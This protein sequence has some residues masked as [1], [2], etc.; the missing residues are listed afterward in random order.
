MQLAELERPKTIL[1]ALLHGL[2]HPRQRKDEIA[3][4]NPPDTIDRMQGATE[5]EMAVWQIESGFN[6]LQ[7]IRLALQ[8]IDEGTYGTCVACDNAIGQKRLNAIPWAS[9]CVKCQDNA[10][11]QIRRRESGQLLR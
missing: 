10:D 3:V 11:R 4:D 6:R 7:S 1:L 5:R 9:L 2:E 8:R